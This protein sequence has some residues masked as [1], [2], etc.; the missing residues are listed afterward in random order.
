MKIKKESL[1]ILQVLSKI[2]LVPNSPYFGLFALLST[3]LKRKR[4]YNLENAA[5]FI[6]LWFGICIPSKPR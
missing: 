4:N 5:I 1:H 6:F 2:S 3:Q